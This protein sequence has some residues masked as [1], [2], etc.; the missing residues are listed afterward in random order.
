MKYTHSSAS[1][2][3]SETQ[4]SIRNLFGKMNHVAPIDTKVVGRCVLTCRVTSP[5]WRVMEEEHKLVCYKP[6][7]LHMENILL[8]LLNFIGKETEAHGYKLDVHSHQDKGLQIQ[9]GDTYPVSVR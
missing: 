1:L 5:G 7:R 8:Q 4:S 3:T 9:L 2:A 6:S